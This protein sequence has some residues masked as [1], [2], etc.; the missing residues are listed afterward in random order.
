MKQLYKIQLYEL[1]GGDMVK[2][3]CIWTTLSYILDDWSHQMG[4]SIDI[5]DAIGFSGYFSEYD[6][7]V[8]YNNQS[9]IECEHGFK[10]LEVRLQ[11]LH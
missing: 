2:R 3:E 10:I 6:M 8:R 7:Y 4:Y 1:F 11:G 5:Y 9:W